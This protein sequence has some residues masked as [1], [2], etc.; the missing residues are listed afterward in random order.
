MNSNSNVVERSGNKSASCIKIEH[1]SNLAFYFGMTI[2]PFIDIFPNIKESLPSNFAG[3]LSM[4]LLFV[5]FMLSVKNTR[6]WIKLYII[7]TF[8][9]VIL[10]YST[11]VSNHQMI[12][13]IIFDKS[14]IISYSVALY[15]LTAVDSSKTLQKMYI[16]SY[17]SIII[18]TIQIFAGNF[19]VNGHFSYMGFGYTFVFYWLFICFKAF[20]QRKIHDIFITLV[21][22]III[23]LGGNRG[24]LLIQIIA[25]LFLNRKYLNIKKRLGAVMVLATMVLII[26]I[27]SNTYMDVLN[28]LM[29][30]LKIPNILAQR[31]NTNM[32]LD[33][34]G[35]NRIS[36]I[37]IQ[38]IS[39]NPLFGYG[40]GADRILI[41]THSHNL[42]LELLLNY[43]IILGGILIF[44][45][46]VLSANIIFQSKH[47]DWA[48]LVA[49]YAIYTITMLSLSSSV[50]DCPEFYTLLVLALN[51]FMIPNKRNSMIERSIL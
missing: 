30:Y 49:I 22:G 35:R 18:Y 41:G 14:D 12:S 20:K 25:L 27:W 50:Y 3:I 6:I 9:I 34:S 51:Y 1:L 2:M 32:F 47:R 42:F 37:V 46:I 7:S 45:L 48:D 29:D 39:S 38:L 13:S 19:I 28:Q 40:I 5:A 15:F 16:I 8:I 31:L 17:I 26:F 11:V 44:L 33:D 21:I 10:I 4:L 23:A 36:Y 24:A 43:G